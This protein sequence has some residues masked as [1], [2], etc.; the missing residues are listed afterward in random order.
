MHCYS[1]IDSHW[2]TISLYKANAFIMIILTLFNKYIKYKVTL[3]YSILHLQ[4][5]Y[6]S[7]FK[8]NIVNLFSQMFF[9]LNCDSHDDI[10][11]LCLLFFL[12]I[13]FFV[14]RFWFCGWLGSTSQRQ[15]QIAE[16]PVIYRI[17]EMTKVLVRVFGSFH[18][19][20]LMFD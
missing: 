7:N 3:F 11:F 14:Q 10:S 4:H 15:K 13:I 8:Y 16:Q 2:S 17:N 18:P 9:I 12:S 19:I 6:K 1:Y 5:N 20:P